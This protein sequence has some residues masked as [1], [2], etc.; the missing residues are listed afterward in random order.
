MAAGQGGKKLLIISGIF[1]PKSGGPSSF[2]AYFIPEI[3]KRGFE[4][5]V[6]TYGQTQPEDEKQ[7]YKIIR[8]S[9]KGNKIGRILKLFWT[10]LELAKDCDQI[11]SFDLYSP[12]L[13]ACFA[14]KILRKRA[15]SRF[16]GDS[17]WEVA[18]NKG[19]TK[20]DIVAF[21]DKFISPKIALIKFCR[22]IIL[23]NCSAIVTDSF[24]LQALLVKLGVKKE[25][26]FVVHNAVDYLPLPANF[27]R[28]KFRQDKGLKN[29]VILT[30]SRLVPWKGVGTVLDILP[31]IKKEAGEVSFICIGDGP[32]SN[33]LKKQA[34]ELKKRDSELDIRFLGNISRQE[35]VLW[36]LAADVYVLNTNYEGIAHTLV[37][38]LYFETPIVTTF[39]GGNPE[40]IENGLNGLLVQYDDQL[41][42]T[43]AINRILT[44]KE[45]IGRL[46]NNSKAK[47]KDDF[48]WE[49]VIEVNLK[50]LGI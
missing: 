34:E 44:D 33:N 14:S 11:Y 39:A 20:D 49:K 42:L 24:F 7:T 15:I 10:A 21:Q 25:K 32:E 1:P 45:L 28:D 9:Q 30:I 13:A 19:L 29:K 23:R 6:L 37:E 12:G 26:I 50:A 48:I 35:A 3:I 22:N 47:L 38:A 8:L 36:F 46:K 40:V 17:A 4:V 18:Q 16:T 31:A 41:Q 2:L 27:D 43:A 5:S